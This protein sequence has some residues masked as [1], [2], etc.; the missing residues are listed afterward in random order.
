ML[1]ATLKNMAQSE[2]FDKTF[3]GFFRYVKKR[4]W[5][6][7][8]NEKTLYDNALLLKVY[9]KAYKTYNQEIYKATA[10]EIENFIYDELKNDMLY[11]SC[12]LYENEKTLIDTNI[13]TSWNAM[14]VDALF[15]L[16][17]I[18]EKYLKKATNLLDD[19]LKHTFK[20]DTLYHITSPMIKG[21]LEDYA[22][23]AK[24]LLSGYEKTNNEQYLINAQ[25]FINQALSQ[26]YDNGVW[27]VKKNDYHLKAEIH[28][29]IYTSSVS[30]MV[31]NLLKLTD[32]IK[33]YKYK[34]FAF[35]TL[36]YNS[37]ELSR[38]PSLYPSLFNQALKYILHYKI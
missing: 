38:K 6:E 14:Y 11:H 7:P 15:C 10:I 3:K 22:F 23:L 29:N 4:N 16:S 8:S 13:Q 37:Y 1:H 9:A 31:E 25:Y 35:K 36:E 20:E 32:F 26:F 28:D 12:I 30:V 33:D 21:Y 17:D 18:E 5:Q 34:T 27:Y 24:A 2:M 19:I